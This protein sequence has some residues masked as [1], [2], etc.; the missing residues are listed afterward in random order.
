MLD[1]ECEH[2]VDLWQDLVASIDEMD[3]VKF[4]DVVKEFDSMSR[5]VSFLILMSFCVVITSS[6]KRYMKII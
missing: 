5:L 6:V 3:I 4:T 1:P 2:F